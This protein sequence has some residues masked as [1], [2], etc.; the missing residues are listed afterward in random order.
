[1]KENG[2]GQ[3]WQWLKDS[4]QYKPPGESKEFVLPERQVENERAKNIVD[5]AKKSR[6]EDLARGSHEVEILSEQNERQAQKRAEEIEPLILSYQHGHRYRVTVSSSIDENKAVLAARYH[7]PRN[8]DLQLREFNLSGEQ[9]CR[10][11]LAYIDGMVDKK[12]LTEAVIKPLMLYKNERA[13]RTGRELTDYMIESLLPNTQAERMAELT[14]VYQAI[15][16]GDCVIFIEGSGEALTADV[17][18]FPSRGIGKTDIERTTRGSQT[19]FGEVL[20]QNT[21]MLHAM[22][23]SSDFVTEL[24]QIGR[25]NGKFCAVM[26]L[27]GIVNETA[28][29]ELVRRIKGTRNDAVFDTGVFSQMLSNNR[30]QFPENLS[31][32]RPDRVVAAMTQG[33]I[34]IMVDGDPF[35]YVA[36]VT[37]WDFFH[38]PEDYEMRLPAALFMRLLRYIGTITALLLP[39]IYIS[40][41]L[42]HHEAIPTEILLAISGYRQFVPFSSIME[43]FFMIMAFELIRESTMR[44]PGQLGSSI[45][46]VG[47]IILGQA[48]V[49]A[50]IVSPLLIVVV[51]ITGLA[52][53]ILPEYRLGFAIRVT[54]Y[55]VLLAGFMFGLVGVS[56]VCVFLIAE[57][58]SIKSLGVPYLAPLAPMTSSV[59]DILRIPSAI[60]ADMWRPDELNT[61]RRQKKVT[62]EELWRSETPQQKKDGNG[63]ENDEL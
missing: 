60:S 43:T 16:G 56:M 19:A 9:P 57:M 48:A 50:K 40:L 1:M 13:D 52:S 26:Y 29:R 35:A 45:G 59:G 28:R 37:L 8:R 7:M 17:K 5:M 54:Q 10:V 31:T 33:R 51:A 3:G 47:A 24:F 53:Y 15:N 25:I 44:V 32:E 61:E 62:P 22:L 58:V 18:G 27:D 49:S 63:E 41:V 6:Q 30:M 38:T 46:I 21:A 12:L 34:V 42:Y 20:R 14:A 39:G 11:M 23:Q 36:P 2:F 4:L 55:A